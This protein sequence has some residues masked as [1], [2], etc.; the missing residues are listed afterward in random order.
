MAQRVGLSVGPDPER[1]WVSR[2]AQQAPRPPVPDMHGCGPQDVL[3]R[4]PAARSWPE[5]TRGQE[6]GDGFTGVG[7]GVGIGLPPTGGD[8]SVAGGT[9][10]A[11]SPPH[12]ASAADNVKAASTADALRGICTDVAP[13]TRS[14]VTSLCPGRTDRHR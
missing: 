4:P 11:S 3:G 8:S 14:P 6:V 2:H 13:V 9:S 5:P 7:T 12:P 1:R 10:A